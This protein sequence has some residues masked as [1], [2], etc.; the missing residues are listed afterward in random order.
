MS[1]D[2]KSWSTEKLNR[3]IDQEYEMASLAAQNGDRADA[4]RR[5]ALVNRYK[6]EIR[7]RYS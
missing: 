6:A 2:I 7:E 1:E 3:K 4:N 5:M